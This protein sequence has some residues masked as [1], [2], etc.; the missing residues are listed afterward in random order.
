MNAGITDALAA[1]DPSDVH[2]FLPAANAVQKLISEA[3][4]GELFKVIAFSRDRRH[5]RRVRARRPLARALTGRGPVSIWNAHSCDMIFLIW[6]CHENGRSPRCA[7]CEYVQ[8][9]RRR[10]PRERPF[11]WQRMR[12]PYGNRP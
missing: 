9:S 8:Y 4:M 12:V 5:A 11:S 6:G 1:I 3:E 7:P 10:A 2:Q